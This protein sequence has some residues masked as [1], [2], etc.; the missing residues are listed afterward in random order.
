MRTVHEFHSTEEA[1]GA[2]QCRD[3]VKRG[4]TLHIPREKVVGIADTWPLAITEEYG[5]LHTAR[6]GS[7]RHAI[8]FNEYGTPIGIEAGKDAVEFA[9]TQGYV[10]QKEAEVL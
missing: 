4:D 6:P 3:E 5:E 2:C 9:K 8:E 10:L 7:L 1:Y